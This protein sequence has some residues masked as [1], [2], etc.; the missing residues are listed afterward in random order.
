MRKPTP[1]GIGRAVDQ[2]T[3]L[4]DEDP[5]SEFSHDALH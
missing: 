4:P 2:E 1:E 5:R 3:L